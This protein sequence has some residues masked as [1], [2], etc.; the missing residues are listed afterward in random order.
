MHKDGYGIKTIANTKKAKSWVSAHFTDFF[1]PADHNVDPDMKQRQMGF[2]MTVDTP[3]GRQ[4]ADRTN[5][6]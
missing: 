4:Q 2:T 1:D 3:N 6:I 5:K